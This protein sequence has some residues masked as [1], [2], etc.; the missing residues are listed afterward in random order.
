MQGHAVRV[1][2]VLDRAR[3]PRVKV[4]VQDAD[5]ADC[6]F[7]CDGEFVDEAPHQP[8]MRIRLNENL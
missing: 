1:I 4:M 6:R 8:P 2:P 7:H 5:E 3:F